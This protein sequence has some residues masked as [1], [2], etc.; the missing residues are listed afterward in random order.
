MFGILQ[1]REK[2][3]PVVEYRDC[4]SAAMLTTAYGAAG[5]GTPTRETGV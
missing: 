2:D 3:T 5:E 1:R 4:Q